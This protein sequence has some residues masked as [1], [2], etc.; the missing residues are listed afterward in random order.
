MNIHFFLRST[1]TDACFS[2][3]HDGKR[4]L[5]MLLPCRMRGSALLQHLIVSIKLVQM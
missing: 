1:E 3:W 5:L 4:P 2:A